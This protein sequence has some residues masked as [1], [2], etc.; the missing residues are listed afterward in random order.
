MSWKGDEI[1][2]NE[3]VEQNYPFSPHGHLIEPKIELIEDVN[4][5][6]NDINAELGEQ[7]QTDKIPGEN[8]IINLR[9]TFPTLEDVQ[10]AITKLSDSTFCKFVISTNSVERR[11]SEH[12]RR[13]V[14]K[15]R[16]GEGRVSKS[17]G[18][19]ASSS[20]NVGCPAFLRIKQTSHAPYCYKVISGNLEHKG[21]DKDAENYLKLKKKLTKDQEE[22]INVLL[23]TEHSIKDIAE[24]LCDL[25]GKEYSIRA[26]RSIKR[27]LMNGWK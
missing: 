9:S 20:K 19:R 7:E 6:N 14:Y 12:T 21:H 2:D 16:Y 4:D 23:R 26:A 8:S 17:K 10:E 24:F 5:S 3:M 1:P 11:G 27:R 25:T 13:I 15:C 18:I 22:A